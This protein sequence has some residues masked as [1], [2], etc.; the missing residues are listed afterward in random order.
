[1]LSIDAI[2]QVIRTHPVKVKLAAIVA[3]LYVVFNVWFFF[4]AKSGGSKTNPVTNVTEKIKNF[5]SPKD[6]SLEHPT[7]PTTPTP[8]SKTGPG[9][10]GCDPYGV[11]NLYQPDLL[12]EACTVTF[13]DSLC[14]D[15]CSDPAK[16]CK[17]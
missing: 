16:R 4:A 14:L 2:R 8:T 11:C 3:I 7:A 5:G 9:P 12:K 17:K 13:A 6:S 10:H 15:K 1:M